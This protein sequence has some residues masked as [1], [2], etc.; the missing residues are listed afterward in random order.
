[1]YHYHP[2]QDNINTVSGKT[3]SYPFLTT[4][5][6][7]FNPNG[8]GLDQ[9]NQG[10]QGLFFSRPT[11]SQLAP[12]PRVESNSIYLSQSLTQILSSLGHNLNENPRKGFAIVSACTDTWKDAMISR[13]NNQEERILSLEHNLLVM[14]NTIQGSVT[15]SCTDENKL[16]D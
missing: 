1:M 13:H 3:G 7:V 10:A 14:N 12:R 8:A 5:D 15:S 4:N 2:A 16:H 6:Q 11:A 9:N